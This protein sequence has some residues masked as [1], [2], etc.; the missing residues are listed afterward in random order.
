[1]QIFAFLF[2][3]GNQVFY[4]GKILKIESFLCS[5]NDL[6][7]HNFADANLDFINLRRLLPL[8]LPSAD[9]N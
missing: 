9:V 7:R 2:Y 1:M 5:K 8:Q 4:V 3:I 6:R